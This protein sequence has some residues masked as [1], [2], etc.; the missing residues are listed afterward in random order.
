MKSEN[1]TIRL[2]PEEKECWKL[3]AERLDISVSHLVRRAMK[4]YLKE[5]K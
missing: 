4:E 3:V 2:T 5:N 1:L